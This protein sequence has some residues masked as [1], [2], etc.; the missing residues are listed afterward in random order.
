MIVYLSLGA[1]LGDREKT[2]NE[3]I[4]L[5]S[6]SGNVFCQSH[7][8]YSEPWGFESAYPFCNCCVG[9]RTKQDLF[10][11]LEDTQAIERQLGRTAKSR[12]AVSSD[13]PVYA[14]RCIDIDL[15]RA[16]DEKGD[17]IFISSPTLTIPHPL[18]EQRDFVVVPLRELLLD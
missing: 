3:A 10:A 1:N 16:F 11:L 5:L 12:P 17:E 13:K 14:D 7:F 9:I 8:Y 6:R 4:S 18:W 15:I 2:I